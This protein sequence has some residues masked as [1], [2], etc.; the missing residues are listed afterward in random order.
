MALDEAGH[1]VRSSKVRHCGTFC[2]SSS[3]YMYEWDL[4]RSVSFY[5]CCSI[6]ITSIHSMNWVVHV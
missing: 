6:E 2:R 4:E 5:G 3:G 1:N